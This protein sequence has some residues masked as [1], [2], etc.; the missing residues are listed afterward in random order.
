M[1]NLNGGLA[2]A[3]GAAGYPGSLFVGPKSSTMPVLFL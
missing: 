1:I 3:D 2:N